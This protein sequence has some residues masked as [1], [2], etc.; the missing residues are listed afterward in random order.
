MTNVDAFESAFRSADKATFSFERPAV[1]RVLVVSDLDGAPATDFGHGVRSF[2]EPLGSEVEWRDA[3][4]DDF[5]TLE[6]LLENVAEAA[7]DLVCT[8]RNL[9]SEAWRFPHSLGEH[10]DVLTQVAPSPVLLMP[11][12]AA[13]RAREGA[14][15]RTPR[16]TMALSGHLT[17][18]ADLV[19]WAAS[20][21][22]PGGQLIL[23][24]VEDDA[25][26]E[27]YMD[28]ISKIAEIDTATA[29]EKI[30]GRLLNEP[31]DY[32]ERCASGLAAA[33]LDLEVE[34][35]VTVGHRLREIREAILGRGVELLAMHTRDDE[36]LA[37]HG[38]AYALA[39]EIRA[40]PVLLL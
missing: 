3:H 39:V 38:Q 14:G 2:L 24:H 13:G 37:M 9:G 40:I 20:L 36:Q 34:T 10:V 26:F 7:P 23:A 11:H 27:R 19:D 29:R 30:R 31:S 25:V 22:A 17:G 32:A 4:V 1:R 16:R 21:C 5:R 15:T 8:Y 33:G 28:A 18:E 35:L 12:P 6:G